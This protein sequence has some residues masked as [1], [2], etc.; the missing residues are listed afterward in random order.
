[1]ID[2]YTMIERG[3]E[4]GDRERERQRKRVIEREIVRTN[5]FSCTKSVTVS[6]KLIVI[7]RKRDRQNNVRDFVCV[8]PLSKVVGLHLRC[9]LALN[10]R[11]TFQ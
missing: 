6:N 1:M 3:K 8:L 2:K 10:Q 7:T 5:G 11:L 9:D 4:E